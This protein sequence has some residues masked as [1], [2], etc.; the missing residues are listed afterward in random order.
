MSDEC[1]NIIF[2]TTNWQRFDIVAALGADRMDT[3]NLGRLVEEGVAFTGCYITVPSC[4][5]SRAIPVHQLLPAH[6]R[7]LQ[8]R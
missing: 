4:A 8:E 3:P 2:I 5:P 6:N 7:H 1:L